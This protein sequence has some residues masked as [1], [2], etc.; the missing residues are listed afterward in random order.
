[1][2]TSRLYRTMPKWKWLLCS[3]S[4]VFFEANTLCEWKCHFPSQYSYT[5]AHWV[6]WH[7]RHIFAWF[8]FHCI[9]IKFSKR[10]DC[11]HTLEHRLYMARF[12]FSPR[13]IFHRVTFAPF[14]FVYL[15]LFLAN[16]PPSADACIA[17]TDLRQCVCARLCVPAFVWVAFVWEKRVFHGIFS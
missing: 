13:F 17:A 10:C 6:L 1:M 2:H 4:T 7:I 11:V 12:S 8:T 3:V 16:F 9:S 14:D 5:Q 15:T